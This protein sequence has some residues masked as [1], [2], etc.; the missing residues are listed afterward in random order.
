MAGVVEMAKKNGAKSKAVELKAQHGY[1]Y[2]TVKQGQAAVQ[3]S[4]QMES[5]EGGVSTK[6]YN[7]GDL[8]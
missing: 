1:L 6:G 2:L 8:R 4:A 3:S 5:R 7:R